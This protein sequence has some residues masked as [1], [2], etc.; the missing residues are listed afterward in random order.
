MGNQKNNLRSKNSK[1]KDL[2]SLK[3]LPSKKAAVRPGKKNLAIDVKARKDY[4]SIIEIFKRKL[5]N[6]PLAKMPADLK[7]MLATLVDEPFTDDAW[8]FELKLDGYRTLAYLRSGK[9][10]LRS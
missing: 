10:E 5:T 9:V 4:T 1:S 2:S 6:S 7:P 8:Q 3:K